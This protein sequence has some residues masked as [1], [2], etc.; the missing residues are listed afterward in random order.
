MNSPVS[1]IGEFNLINAISSQIITSASVLRGIGDDCA[2]IRHRPGKHLLFTTDMLIEGAHFKK[3][4]KPSF[5]G[6]KAL[7]VN[8]SDVASCG[9]LPK[10]AVVALGLPPDTKGSFV[11]DMYKGMRRLAGRF[12]IDIVG[13]DTNRCRKIIISVALLGQVAAR[14]LVT[15]DGARE[16][17]LLV[18]SGPLSEKPDHLCFLPKIKESRFI[19]KNL[20]PT[21]MIDISDGLLADLGHI[22]RMSRKKAVL[23]ES[24]IPV[25]KRAGGIDKV[26]QTGE[27][28]QLMFTMPADRA[29]FIPKGFFVIG[30]ICKGA[31]SIIMVGPSGRRRRL[32]PKGYT[33]F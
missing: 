7:A 31:P 21:S 12:N 23:Y 20:M 10:W 4:T 16:A 11:S 1:E 22:L 28:F 14:E 30:R 19:V 25:I 8:I 29:R 32:L 24:A 9:G 6:H 2:V 27:Q 33:H 13:G 18:L 15:R 3:T 26:L 17:D 5:I